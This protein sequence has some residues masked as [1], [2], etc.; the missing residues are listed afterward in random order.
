MALEDTWQYLKQVMDPT[1]ARDERM[2]GMAD[3][4]LAPYSQVDGPA[5][6]FGYSAQEWEN[7]AQQNPQRYEQMKLIQDLGRQKR[8]REEPRTR[9]QNKEWAPRWAHAYGADHFAQEG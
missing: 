1:Q 4:G 8:W 2:Q 5:T 7:I 9:T 3:S 6:E